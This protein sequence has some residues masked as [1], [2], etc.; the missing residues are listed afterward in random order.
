MKQMRFWIALSAVMTAFGLLAGER[1][2]ATDGRGREEFRSPQGA[3]REN[4]GRRA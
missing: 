3:A 2:V 4:T 1:F